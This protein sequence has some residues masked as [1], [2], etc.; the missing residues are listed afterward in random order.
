MA[1]INIENISDL[2]LN[3][4]DLFEDSESFITELD[5]NEQAIMGGCAVTNIGNCDNTV[6]DC[7]VTINIT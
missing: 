2:A 5:D 7:R 6:G 3:G 4:N 1:N